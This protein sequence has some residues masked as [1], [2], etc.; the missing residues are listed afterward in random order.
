MARPPTARRTSRRAVALCRARG[1]THAARRSRSPS[2]AACWWNAATPLRRW[3]PRARPSQQLQARGD[4]GLGSMFTPASAWWWHTRALQANGLQAQARQAL[5]TSY[6]VMLD[7]V[8]SLSDEGLRR[9]WF[10]KVPAHRQLIRAWLAEGRRRG[11]PRARTLAHLS[12]HTQLREPFERL[13]D[14]GVRL[15]QLHSAAELHE[16]LVEEATELSGAER[17]LLVLADGDELRHR[18]LAAAAGRG[19]RGAA[20]GHPPWLDE[21][22]HTRAGAPAP[23]PRGRRRRGPALLP[24]G[25]AGGAA[26]AAGLP[27]CRHRRRLRPLPRRRSR[28]AGHAGRA[29]RGGAGQHPRQRGAGGQGGRAHRSSWNSAP[30]SSRSSTASS[31]AWPTKPSFQAIVDLVGDRLRE[32]FDDRRRAHRLVGRRGRR[33]PLPVRATSTACAWRSQP[34]RAQPGRAA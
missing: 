30:A 19:R 5:A 16:F 15:N 29:G 32:V 33:R 24:G 4:A 20:A 22:R 10:N 12:A 3:P 26:P 18:R 28:P 25:A 11:L 34:T 7:G 9:S 1:D 13:V 17:V 31:R 27:V 14:T 8:A 23:R 21:A 2:W 6:R